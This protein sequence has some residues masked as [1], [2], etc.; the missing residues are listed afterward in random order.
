MHFLIGIVGCSIN[1]SGQVAINE[2]NSKKGFLNGQGNDVDWIEVFNAGADSILLGQYYLSDNGNNLDKWRFPNIVLRS[3]EIITVCATGNENF[4]FPHHWESIVKA[5]NMWKYW[6]NPSPPPN[7]YQWNNLGYNDQSWSIGQGGIG[8]GDN[9]D[10]TVINA[11]PSVLLRKEFEIIEIE[12]ITHLMFHADYDDGFVAYLNGTEFMRSDNLNPIPS[13]NELTSS[14]HEAVLYSG[15]DPDHII[16]ESEEIDGLLHQGTNILAISVHNFS[17]NS[18]DL[19]GNFF[20]SAGISSD[21]YFYQNLP[22]WITPPLIF[23]QA[24]FKLSAGETIVISDTNS[25]IIDS[26]SVPDNLTRTISQGRIP[27]G[28]GSWCYFDNP[29]PNTSNSQN[30]CYTAISKIAEIDRPSGWYSSAIQVNINTPPDFT[31]Y[32]TTNG[33]EPDELDSKV[34]GPITVSST[35]ILSVR[36]Y[37]DNGTEIP[38]NVEDRTYIISEDNHNLPV[39][40]IITNEDHLW[41]WNTGIYVMGPNASNVYPYF[42]S[43]FWQPWS[44]KSRLEFFDEGKEKQFDAVFDLEIH[45]GWSRAEAQKSFRVDAKSIYTGDIE[46]TLIK[47]KPQITSYNNFNLRNGGQHGISNRIQDAII[48]RLA[49][50][51]NIDRMGYEPCIVYLNGTYWGLYGIREKIDEHYVESNHSIDKDYVELLN[52]DGALAGSTQHFIESHDLILS[53]NINSPDF[54]DVFH[55]RFDMSNY[56]D[57]FI[58]Q[59]YIQ[60]RDWLGIDWGLNNVKLWRPDTSGGKWRYV[61][62]D[63]DFAF[64]LYGGNIYQNYINRARN[65]NTQNEHAELFDHVLKNDAFK[66]DF[67]NRYDDLINTTFQSEN[68]NSITDE[69]RL[70]LAP[71]I[72][73]H[74]AAWSNQMGPY[75]YND[76]LN[77]I[78]GIKSYNTARIATAR[79]HINQSFS[80]LGQKAVDLDEFPS[81]SGIINI[82]SIAP[83]LPWNGIYHGGCDIS[84]KAI[85]RK[86]YVFTHWSSN[87]SNYDNLEDE[88]MS[89]SLTGNTEFVANFETCENAIDISIATGAQTLYAIT[90]EELSNVSYEWTLNN[91]LVSSDSAIFNPYNG[92]YKVTVA[93]DSC[94]VESEGLNVN[95]DLYNI[96]VFPNPAVDKVNVQFLI[97]EVTTLT[98]SLVNTIGQE[99]WVEKNE[100]FVGQY[101]RAIDVS[102]FAQGVYYLH[103][104]FSNVHYS[105]KI[106]VRE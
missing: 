74:I 91:V 37:A 103:V 1:L 88:S 28:T 41:D 46:Y 16:F 26:I 65:P 39:I 72:P 66:C 11:T 93:F 10:N 84:L 89:V 105:Q 15:G 6:S 87:N 57:Y 5:E 100:G 4:K 49:D 83:K 19:S 7:Y 51:T 23:P 106:I 75:Y 52:R 58:F 47:R 43:N 38:S 96:H 85:A 48:S 53:T 20:L 56:I 71:A 69:L 82:N 25:T 55:S 30:I 3:N 17:A 32:F 13:Y 94:E 18:S 9:D 86:G 92:T 35:G 29:S 12:D 33:D 59:T 50:G 80:L 77:S 54:A 36:T 21:E 45:G 95:E 79:Q 8:Y 68:F 22:N 63:T 97:P 64:G 34:Q 42:G 60:N 44:K 81:N 90:S 27:D 2:F 31:S 104:S 102:H 76:W 40:S 73:D 101:N 78:N 98:N 99:L 61:L 62:Y 70:Q 67:V 14:I 24:S